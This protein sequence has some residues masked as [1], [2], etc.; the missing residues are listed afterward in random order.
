LVRQRRNAAGA[1]AEYY[2][3]AQTHRLIERFNSNYWLRH[4]AE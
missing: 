3:R 1:H 2:V 4:Y